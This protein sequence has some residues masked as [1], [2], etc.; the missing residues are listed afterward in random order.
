M[1]DVSKREQWGGGKTRVRIAWIVLTEN[2]KS[3]LRRPRD[4]LYSVRDKD[5][6]K[7]KDKGNKMRKKKL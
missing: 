2:S 6:G 4:S 7:M 1:T 5:H 3:E